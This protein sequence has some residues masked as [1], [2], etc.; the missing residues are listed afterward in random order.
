[1]MANPESESFQEIVRA[2]MN[3][4]TAEHVEHWYD[5]DPIKTVSAQIPVGEK[6]SDW[7]NSFRSACGTP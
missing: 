3:R 6:S 5:R 1:M 7:S 2:L 4:E